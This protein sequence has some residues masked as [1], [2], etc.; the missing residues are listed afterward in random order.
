MRHIIDIIDNF[1]KTPYQDE[2]IAVYKAASAINHLRYEVLVKDTQ[3]I[4]FS[5][6]LNT[7]GTI[8]GIIY[9]PGKHWEEYLLHVS[10][11]YSEPYTERL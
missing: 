6:N 10:D 4:V 1:P 8:T 7:D 11:I 2:K 9:R 5:A 3:T